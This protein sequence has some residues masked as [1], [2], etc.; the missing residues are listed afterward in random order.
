MVLPVSRGLQGWMLHPRHKAHPQAITGHRQDSM[1]T[2]PLPPRAVGVLLLV[3]LVIP[4]AVGRQE[5]QARA[6]RQASIPPGD[7]P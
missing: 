6:H 4:A 2:G 3:T 1:L 5:V 7:L